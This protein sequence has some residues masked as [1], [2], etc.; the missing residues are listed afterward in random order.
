MKRS[1]IY[2]LTILAIILSI[3]ANAPNLWEYL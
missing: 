3:C 1:T 2:L